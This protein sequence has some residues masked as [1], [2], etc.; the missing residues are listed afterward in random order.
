M[1]SWLAQTTARIQAMFRR[2]SLDR[3][4]EEELETHV[5]L[6]TEENIRSGMEPKAARRAAVLKIG[7]RDAAIELHREARGFPMIEDLVKDV[8]HGA[9]LLGRNPIFALTAALSLGIPKDFAMLPVAA[10]VY[11]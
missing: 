7:S 6:M 1:F 11:R 4:V 5:E 9:R 3:H 8:R 2:S 10:I